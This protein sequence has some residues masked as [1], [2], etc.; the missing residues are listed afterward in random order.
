[1]KYER[2]YSSVFPK[3]E[4]HL[5][6]EVS[7]NLSYCSEFAQRVRRYRI[8]LIHPYEQ[9]RRAYELMICNSFSIS[10]LVMQ[11]CAAYLESALY[12]L[13]WKYLERCGAE[14]LALHRNL[15]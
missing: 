10:P 5:H 15:L 1:M 8:P 9:L 11:R 13:T 3:V 12:D 2:I 6:I 14:M 4:L 7:P